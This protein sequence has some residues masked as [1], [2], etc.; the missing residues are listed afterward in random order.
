MK[1]IKKLFVS[2]MAVAT[3]A[4]ALPTMPSFATSCR[5][6]GSSYN[7]NINT[8]ETI[9]TSKIIKGTL[10]YASDVDCYKFVPKTTG[11]SIITLS[12][13]KGSMYA[14]EL[15]DSNGETFLYMPGWGTEYG[16][17]KTLWRFQANTTY[18]IKISAY[19]NYTSNNSYQLYVTPTV[20]RG[21]TWY[22]Q[23]QNY[24]NYGNELWND[25][26]LS[27]LHFGSST[28][29]PFND[30]SSNNDFMN[31]GCALACMAMV[32]NNLGAQT[33]NPIEDFRTDYYGYS[34]ADPFT[35]TMANIG[36][37]TAP[38][39]DGKTYT[40]TQSS[41][42]MRLDRPDLVAEYFNKTAKN[43]TTTK[44]FEGIKEK[45][46]EYPKGIVVQFNNA[47]G[48]H[49]VVMVPANNADGFVV[50]DPGTPNPTKANG[51]SFANSYAHLNYGFTEKDIV[52]LV[53]I[54]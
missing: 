37:T 34:Y 11:Y 43:D 13:P 30:N 3:V 28:S 31:E 47:N 24:D 20:D 12:V 18:Y 16:G 44:T 1:R 50:Y 38:T 6:E 52:K 35:V 29:K 21:K 25:Y 27:N 26:K 51:V 7:D 39:W 22:T 49:W 41:N 45:L 46:S 5:N 14:I 19:K 53:L 40:Y 2:A 10:A 17:S 15:C 48:M 23:T 8:T 9:D 4:S 32:L 54:K 36:V 42:P 33:K